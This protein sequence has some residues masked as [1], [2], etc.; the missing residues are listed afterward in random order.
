[1]SRL[2]GDGADGAFPVRSRARAAPEVVYNKQYKPITTQIHTNESPEVVYGH[3]QEQQY[4]QAPGQRPG[5]RRRL[6]G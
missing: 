6:A 2:V 1:M 5:R 3:I 4:E